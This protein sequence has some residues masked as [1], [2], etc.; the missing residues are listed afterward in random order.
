MTT[1]RALALTIAVSAPGLAACGFD[2]FPQIQSG[3][4]VDVALPPPVA[5]RAHAVLFGVL[6][7]P[8][9][10]LLAAPL[11]DDVDESG[12]RAGEGESLDR[13]V[14]DEGSAVQ[15]VPADVQEPEAEH[16]FGNLPEGERSFVV[17]VTDADCAD[18]ACSDVGGNATFA[19]MQGREVARGCRAATVE[20][21]VVEDESEL[22]AFE[23][24]QVPVAPRG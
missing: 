19:D 5:V 15:L 4:T 21:H 24:V 10:A 8:C 22:G 9:T 16:T 14:R 20:A 1:R 23:R 11:G 13:R 2:P 17:V 18:V 3:M 12:A 7:A 6:D